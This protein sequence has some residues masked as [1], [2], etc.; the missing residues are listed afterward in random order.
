MARLPRLALQVAPLV[1][2]AACKPK[3]TTDTYYCGPEELCP[4]GLSCHLGP[5][6]SDDGN[7]RASFAY[8]CVTSLAA[9]DFACSENTSDRE[10]DDEPALGLDLM[11]L[12]C[13]SQ[14]V[15]EDWG[16]IDSAGDL[17]HYQF[18]VADVCAG[19]NP[20][21]EVNLSY[22]IGAAPV[23]VDLLDGTGE[24]LASGEICTG[25]ADEGG[26]EE[27]CITM[28]ELPIGD[29]VLRI[30]LDPDGN[31]DCDGACAFNRYQLRLSTP[32]S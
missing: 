9:G 21:F 24:T 20:R 25:A 11:D 15:Q 30:R 18:H 16:C 4:P 5:T 6:R 22:P 14:V 26:V 10:P 12:G 19:S 17:D 1:I 31:A 3:I 27:R 13:G 8:S 7:Q 2:I 23:S 29:Y 28:P 32:I